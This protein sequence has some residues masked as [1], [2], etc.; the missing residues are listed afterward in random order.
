MKFFLLHTRLILIKGFI[1]LENISIFHRHKYLQQNN[2]SACT[3][4]TN[5]TEPWW[6]V[7]LQARIEVAYVKIYAKSYDFLV[8]HIQV[9]WKLLL[10]LFLD[11]D[12]PYFR[13]LSDIKQH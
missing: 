13:F 2:F 11:F 12:H 10:G 5:E 9:R 6:E 4:T 8:D 1:P 3:R 7:D